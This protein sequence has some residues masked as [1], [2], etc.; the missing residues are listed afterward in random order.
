MAN[1]ACT[2]RTSGRADGAERVR[3]VGRTGADRARTVEW[4]GGRGPQGAD[5]ADR[6]KRRGWGR[7]GADMA[8][9]AQMGPSRRGWAEWTVCA[10]IAR[11]AGR[12]YERT[13]GLG[14][15]GR[16]SRGQADWTDRRTGIP[17]VG[18]TGR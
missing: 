13:G 12:A 1:D 14:G 11:T 9:Q 5:R 6:R 16:K 2:K 15:R 18:R 17:A 3:T 8:Q 10:S 7:G 4:T